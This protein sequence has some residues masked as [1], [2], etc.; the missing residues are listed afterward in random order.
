MRSLAVGGSI[1]AWRLENGW[2]AVRGA[3]REHEHTGEWA[4]SNPPPSALV[5]PRAQQC[6]R[7]MLFVSVAVPLFHGGC[8]SR[9]RDILPDGGSAATV[10]TSVAEASLAYL[11]VSAA[12]R[13]PNLDRQAYD[14]ALCARQQHPHREPTLAQEKWTRRRQ[15]PYVA[16]SHLP[17]P[18]K[19]GRADDRCRTLH[20]FTYP[21][22]ITLPLS[23][24]KSPHS[25]PHTLPCIHQP[26]LVTSVIDVS[27]AEF[28]N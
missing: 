12:C 23:P 2:R 11:S 16:P 22:K 28:F 25:N 13:S 6:H 17:T 3:L 9:C 18:K 4:P 10:R 14:G 19:S 15:M 5:G 1:Q 27:L 26:H 8:G 21:P 7:H 20:L 24:L